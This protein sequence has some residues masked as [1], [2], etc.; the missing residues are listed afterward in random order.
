MLHGLPGYMYQS[1]P[2]DLDFTDLSVLIGESRS[3]AV[4]SWQVKSS[5]VHLHGYSSALPH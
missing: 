3:C 1:G 5:D 4:Y 2:I